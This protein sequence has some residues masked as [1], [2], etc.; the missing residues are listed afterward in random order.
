[1]RLLVSKA[2]GLKPVSKVQG[3]KRD[4]IH[5]LAFLCLIARYCTAKLPGLH[6]MVSHL[7]GILLIGTTSLLN[8]DALQYRDHSSINRRGFSSKSPRL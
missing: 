6:K 1:M 7:S 8:L 4:C 3:V 2:N 5:G